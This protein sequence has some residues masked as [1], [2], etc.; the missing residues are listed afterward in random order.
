MHAAFPLRP[1][2][3]RLVSSTLAKTNYLTAG[4]PHLNK[5]MKTSR[6]LKCS[7]AL[8][9]LALAASPAFAGTKEQLIQLQT[10]VQALQ[11]QMARMQQ[12][13]DE[14]MGVMRNLVE[15]TTDSV[16]KMNG[17]LSTLDKSVRQQSGDSG[18]KVE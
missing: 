16:N 11:D 1:E 9:L 8:L 3:G 17:S 15:Q 12:S 18:T 7:I 2:P 4:I 5:P 13:F 6:Y 14:R 10:Q